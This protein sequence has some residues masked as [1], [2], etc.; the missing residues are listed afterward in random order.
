MPLQ[1]LPASAVARTHRHLGNFRKDPCYYGGLCDH[2]NDPDH[3]AL[4]SHPP[5]CELARGACPH[6]A[7]PAAAASRADR[8][9]RHAWSHAD[10]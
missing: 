3:L 4:Y 2:I 10:V 1:S 6:W 7:A 9:H 8:V 5:L